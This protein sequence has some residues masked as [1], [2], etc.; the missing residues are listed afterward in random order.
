[1]KLEHKSAVHRDVKPKTI[2]QSVE[3]VARVRI[4]K[5]FSPLKQ[6][7]DAVEDV[8]HASAEVDLNECVSTLAQPSPTVVRMLLGNS[9]DSAACNGDV[10][11]VL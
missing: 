7:I 9:G 3:T 8:L 10:V 4:A 5:L 2:A 6:F 1:M 11:E